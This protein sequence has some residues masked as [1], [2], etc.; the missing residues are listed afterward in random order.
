MNSNGKR[1]DRFRTP[2][3]N[4]SLFVSKS[5]SSKRFN[6][7]PGPTFNDTVCV[8]V[9]ANRSVNPKMKPAVSTTSTLTQTLETDCDIA[10]NDYLQALMKRQI[11]EK[12]IEERKRLLNGQIILQRANL[13]K[14]KCIYQEIKNDIESLKKKEQVIVTI[15]SIRD[16]TSKLKTLYTAYQTEPHIEKIT[17]LL[18]S[19]C[20]EV[21]LKNIVAIKT[22]QEYDNLFGIL[23]NLQSM[24]QKIVDSGRDFKGIHDLAENIRV[25]K[26]HIERI[27]ETKTILNDSKNDSLSALLSNLSEIFAKQYIGL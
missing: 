22:Q 5:S 20:D 23:Q 21:I 11:I 9:S 14:K 19:E 24:L 2:S 13:E 12:E 7:S 27:E 8:S 1:N 4:A 17:K 6:A 18:T 16:N 26:E 15:N 25:S 10:Y 3:H